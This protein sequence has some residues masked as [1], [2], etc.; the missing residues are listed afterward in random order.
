MS[1]I[2]A[3]FNYYNLEWVVQEFS[4]AEKARDFFDSLEYKLKYL[5]EVLRS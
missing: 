4:E 5:A 3:Y 1:Y 2:V